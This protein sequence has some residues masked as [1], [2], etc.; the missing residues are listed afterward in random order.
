MFTHVP[1]TS[2]LLRWQWGL[3]WLFPRFMFHAFRPLFGDQ[4]FFQVQFVAHPI[5]KSVAFSWNRE[6][7]IAESVYNSMQRRQKS[8]NLCFDYRKAKILL[9]M[10][11][12]GRCVCESAICF[13]A[14]GIASMQT[15]G[16]PAQG[17]AQH[18]FIF[19]VFVL[20]IIAC[21]FVCCILI[22]S[23]EKQSDSSRKNPIYVL[24]KVR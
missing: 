24:D 10:N 2:L 9:L 12:N 16:M 21:C 6:A 18:L 15:T 7:Q 22:A 3:L 23:Q 14:F 8:A 11:I 13:I 20:L 1:C 4:K 5:N 19:N 17:G